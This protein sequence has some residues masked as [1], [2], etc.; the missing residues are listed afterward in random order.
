MAQKPGHTAN[1]II[2][3]RLQNSTGKTDLEERGQVRPNTYRRVTSPQRRLKM[4]VQMH[5]FGPHALGSPMVS[6]GPVLLL[7]AVQREKM[8]MLATCKYR[9]VNSDTRNS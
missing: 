8:K 1:R 7:T 6:A 9:Q 4:Q 3:G 2:D 5:L